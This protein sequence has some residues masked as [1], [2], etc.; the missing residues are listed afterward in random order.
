MKILTL[1]DD[2]SL[3]SWLRAEAK[4]LGRRKSDIA[5]E[6]LERRRSG[7]QG[8]S[9]HEIMRDVCGVI[10]GAPRDYASNRK[11]LKGLGRWPKS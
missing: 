10:K 8:Q 9:I 1:K 7:Q 3:D 11:R 2:E 5:R 6:A 4:K